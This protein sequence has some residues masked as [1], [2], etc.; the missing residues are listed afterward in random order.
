MVAGF[1]FSGLVGALL[2]GWMTDKVFGG[3]AARA[4]IFYMALSGLSILLFWKNRLPSELINTG[5][6]CLAGFFIYGPQCL[7]AVIAANLATKRAAASAVGLTGLF[8]YASTV[9]SGVG[10]GTLVQHHGWDAGFA[11]LL[12]VAAIAMILFVL[13]WPAKP[14]GYAT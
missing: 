1:E 14:H 12:L 4:C 2:A 7:V 8:G 10:L 3:R 11:G 5:L 9:L 13:A 6:L